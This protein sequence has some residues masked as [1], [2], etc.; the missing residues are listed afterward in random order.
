RN[1][2]RETAGGRSQYYD[3]ESEQ[4]LRTATPLGQKGLEEWAEFFSG[5]DAEGNPVEIKPED[6]TPQE[7]AEVGQTLKTRI[8]GLTE[9]ELAK[10][11]PVELRHLKEDIASIDRDLLRR[12]P[13]ETSVEHVERTIVDPMTDAEAIEGAKKRGAKADV[14]ADEARRMIVGE[15]AEGRTPEQVAADEAIL[16]AQQMASTIER[17]PVNADDS[18]WEKD[19]AAK[20]L[21][22]YPRAAVGGRWYPLPSTEAEYKAL[23]DGTTYVGDDGN[24]HKKERFDFALRRHDPI[25]LNPAS[26]EDIQKHVFDVFTMNRITLPDGRVAKP[27]EYDRLEAARGAVRLMQT[28]TSPE[29]QAARTTSE[30]VRSNTVTR[31]AWMMSTGLLAIGAAKRIAA[32]E[33]T[34]ENYVTVAAYMEEARKVAEDYEGLP[35]YWKTVEG[36]LHTL[37]F[38]AAL[39]PGAGAA[40]GTRLAVRKTV[41][42]AVEAK[43][44]RVAGKVA[45][46]VAGETARLAV[47]PGLQRMVAGGTVERMAPVDMGLEGLAQGDPF[48]EAFSK[49][50]GSQLISQLTERSGRA[51]FN[52]PGLKQL[53]NTIAGASGRAPGSI[54]SAAEWDGIIAE[55]GEERLEEFAQGIFSGV[56]GDGFQFGPTADVLFG[57]FETT[58]QG[59]H[60]LAIEGLVIGAVGGP[61][62]V[63]DVAARRA[64]ARQLKPLADKWAQGGSATE[65][66]TGRKAVIEDAIPVEG[67]LAWAVQEKND[68][69]VNKLLDITT[70]SRAQ[71]RAA[72]LPPANT[73]VR[74]RFTEDLRQ[75]KD[76]QQPTQEEPDATPTDRV[77]GEQDAGPAEPDAQADE[78]DAEIERLLGPEAEG[79]VSEQAVSEQAAVA[80]EPEGR[81]GVES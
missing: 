20:G 57:D 41:E 71:W 72:G 69:A 31:K 26:Q 37:E 4:R 18:Q 34:K 53:K 55:F 29:A 24:L 44:L 13:N 9:E 21:E 62:P 35:W 68:E 81:E 56:T 64:R 46:E 23:N 10:I 3:A 59:L 36:I 61:G 76:L 27:S 45:G 67:V 60:D 63:V 40:K 8:E 19:A 78:M 47:S 54:R 28:D 12:F 2:T 1:L 5:E 6:I 39:I 11:N 79:G 49:S 52:L 75:L 58:K 80:G 25:V 42:K 77:A 70:P 30:L 43:A 14:T 50:V 7:L 74:R 65:A 48:V 51:L 38:A 17:A 66:M 32:G 33:K 22:S 73:D 15:R 16:D